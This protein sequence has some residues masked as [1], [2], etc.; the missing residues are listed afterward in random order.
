MVITVVSSSRADFGLLLP[1]I[2]AIDASATLQ[3]RVVATGSH[4]EAVHGN[5]VDE[6][7][8]H[9]RV[10]AEVPLAL[11]EDTSDGIGRSMGR[12]LASFPSVFRELGTD[13]VLVLGDRF[14]IL[15]V[16]ESALISRLPVAHLC[17]GDVT[18][19]AWDDAIRHAITKMSHLHF[20]TNVDARRRVIQMGEQ[21]ENVHDVGSPGLDAILA[22]DRLG[23]D[24]LE[25]TL[26]GFRF[27]GTNLLVTY[28]PETLDF[29]DGLARLDALLAALD[30]LGPDTGIVFT[31]PNA[32][33]GGSALGER[34]RT[35]CDARE[36]AV[37]YTSLGQRRYLSLMGEVDAVVGNSSSGL[38]EAPSFGIP[39]VNVGSR[40]AGRLR[41]TS[42]FDVE[43]DADAILAT[44]RE[45][46]A[47]DCSQT[48]NPY[49]DGQ[50]AARITA[51]L[52]GVSDPRAL[53]VKSFRGVES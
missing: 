45:A 40:Q 39:T 28:H 15:A 35:W 49:G 19:G 14:E 43:P 4:L 18:E 13:L 52:E 21:P 10:D 46:L 9:V 34:T 29:G 1:V 8:R 20:P 11:D 23:R 50:S 51:V 7:R 53:L 24:E 22:L 2:R 31:M 36:N 5:T 38:Y 6:M 44:L 17:G 33:L 30:G 3:V 48:V 12:A 16:V 32:D 26:P 47:T 37:A 41:A 42:V 25:A 27:R